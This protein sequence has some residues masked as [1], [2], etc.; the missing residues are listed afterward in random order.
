MLF[1]QVK[2]ESGETT[3]SYVT[4]LRKLAATCEFHDTNDAILD[5]VIEKCYSSEL[6]R[7]ALQERNLTQDKLLQLARAMEAANRQAN[8]IEGNSG[9]NNQVNKVQYNK[10]TKPDQKSYRPKE[11]VKQKSCGR[12]GSTSHTY[13]EIQK[14]PAK[15]KKCLGC[16]KLNHFKQYCKTKKYVYNASEPTSSNTHQGDSLAQEEQS[17][18]N[19][20]FALNTVTGSKGRIMLDVYVNGKFIQMQLDTAADVSVVSEEVAK[21]I[22]NITVTPCDSTLIAYNSQK[23]QVQGLAK[24]DDSHKGKMYNGLPLTVVKEQR[25]SLFGLNWIGEVALEIDLDDYNVNKVL[26]IQPKE[27][28]IKLLEKHKTIFEGD[29]GTVKGVTASLLLKEGANPKFCPPRQIP[30]ALKPLFEQE[31]QRLVDNQSFEKVT[32]SNWGTP[33]IPAVKPDGS[34][35]LCGDF[36]VTVNQQLQVAQHPL[37]KPED[38]FATLGNRLQGTFCFVDDILVAGKNDDE[39][40]D[41]L[42][43]VLRI[44]EEN[45]LNISKNKCEFAV[46]SVGYLGFIADGSGIH[47]TTEKVKAI[48]EAK[49]PENVAELKSFMGLVT[50]YG[51]FIPN[52]AIIAHPLHNLLRNNVE[53]CWT[54]ECDEA[55][56]QIKEDIISPRFLTHFQPDLPVKLTCD[57]SSYG[58]GA[59]LAHFM[60]DKTERLYSIRFSHT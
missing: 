10:Q 56:Y 29:Q 19:F 41:R 20:A 37:P 21:S 53:W 58:L 30:F 7:K 48:K 49:I 28:L 55:V 43:S 9:N 40:L 57:A 2:Q 27:S 6:R 14:C 46:P 50:F 13:Y 31:I 17:F 47:K 32:Y 34:I 33:I 25:P 52:L 23:I 60:P 35:R 44:N 4:R 26:N 5:Q 3:Y 59:V 24:V 18:A 22:P 38:M 16:G 1:N 54:P 15:D 12:C 8:V 39:H 11:F 45:G 51:R 36:K 42:K